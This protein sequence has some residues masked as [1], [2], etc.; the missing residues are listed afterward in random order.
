[1]GM[2]GGFYDF[3]FSFKNKL[4]INTPIMIGVAFSQQLNNDIIVEK[5]DCKLNYIVTQDFILN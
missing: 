1:M 2:G 3:S 4:K 5:H